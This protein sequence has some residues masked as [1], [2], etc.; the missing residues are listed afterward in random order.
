MSGYSVERSTTVDAPPQRVHAL[1]NDFR[2]WTEW[3]PWEDV[4]PDLQRTYAG[5]DQGVGAQYSW[6]GNRKAGA[7]KM[8]I[9]GSTPER[10][11]INLDFLK[12][13][14]SLGNQVRYDFVPEGQGTRVVWRM[15]SEYSGLMKVMGRFMN[16]DKMIG[17]DLE[18][19]LRQ[20]RA[21][22]EGTP[23]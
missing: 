14:K 9:V 11:D 13:F 18:K 10:I 6:T 23:R 2:R 5:P 16:M 22:A 7:G 15:E 3:S 8:E 4:D 12:P 1:V 19:G 21:A 20:L 17:P